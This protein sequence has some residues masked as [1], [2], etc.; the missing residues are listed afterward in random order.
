M[1]KSIRL[2][3]FVW[4]FLQSAGVLASGGSLHFNLLSTAQGLSQVSI[5]AIHQDSDINI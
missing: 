1:N 2:V 3:V 5:I 4:L